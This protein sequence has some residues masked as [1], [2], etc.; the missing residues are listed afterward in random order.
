MNGAGK[1]ECITVYNAKENNLKN[2]TVSFP[3]NQF[4]C[5]TGPSGC[6][7][8]SL[9]FDTIY[10]ESQ[11]NFLESVSG[12]MFG[13]RIMDKP[14]VDKIENLRPA[15]NISQKYYNVNPRSTVGTITDISYYLR[16]LFAFTINQR[17]GSSWDMNHY[18][19]NNPNSCCPKCNGIGEEYFVSEQ[20]VIPDKGKTL[21]AGGILYYKGTKQSQEYKLLE[22]ICERYG[23]DIN[24]KVGDLTAIERES[25]LYRTQKDTFTI[26]FKTPKGR[27]K[28]WPISERGAMVEIENQLNES[29][30]ASSFD[31]IEKYLGKR[32]CSFCQGKRLNKTI[33]EDTIC[34]KSIGDIEQLPISEIKDWCSNV[35]LAYM[36]SP[37]YRQID[38]LLVS[39]MNRAQHL[40]DLK[41]GHLSIGRSIPSLSSGELQRVRLATQLE[42]SLVGMIYI[43]DEPCKGL[44]YKDINSIIQTTRDLV[45]RGNTVIAIEHNSQ[46]ISSADRIVE[47]GPS[48]GPL[49][50][51]ILAEYNGK[52]ETLSLCFKPPRLSK[53]ILSLSGIT[54]RNL[55]SI[56][57]HIPIGCV[58]CITG[59]S[60][61]GKTTLT[62]VIEEVCE[63]G[64]SEHCISSEGLSYVK[65]VTR[66][67]QRPIGKT[68]RST[69]VSYLDIYN[70]IRDLYAKTESAKAL[71][72]GASDF[73]MN[74]AGGRCECCQGTGKKKIEL[75]YLPDSFVLCPECKGK[76]FHDNI[77]SVKYKGY[78]I[79]DIL[80]TDVHSLLGVFENIRTIFSVLSCMD[81]IGMGYVSLGQM[82]MNLSGG[83]AQRIKLAK[84]LGTVSRGGNLFI[85][86]E[87]TSGLNAQDINRLIGII[88]R[89]TENGETVII[90]EH[91]IEFISQVADHL[92]DLGNFAGNAGGKTVVEG[93][94]KMVVDSP[95]TSWRGVFTN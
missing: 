9:V 32:V 35:R 73:S 16:S 74:V 10:A 13:Q 29:K 33:L 92:I 86:D 48:G 85:L 64:E 76:R 58:T 43:L 40:I 72:L 56:N 84:Y 14:R 57:V 7:K 90:I 51:Y 5:V 26:K 65:K 50:G 4:T 93:D 1:T 68:A 59:V 95:G 78:S 80:N 71:G 55:K 42:C 41:L 83:E 8:S 94:P 53:R 44:H 12:N 46:Y 79:A 22:A 37:Y 89:L 34:E 77:L 25:L 15:L 28:T 39:I 60:G 21:A 62:S 52:Q 47:M 69:V 66:I 67:N 75:Q 3:L 54:Y 27:T 87:P 2:V 88:N 23:I 17:S 38:A 61:S 36:T 63:Y 19:A 91:N 20:L 31:R 30:K 18:S 70:T 45:H 82:S 24:K 81:E 11:R 49:G 6:G